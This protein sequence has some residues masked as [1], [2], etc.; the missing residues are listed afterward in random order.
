MTGGR[1]LQEDVEAVRAATDIL[2]VV[3]ERVTLK[4]SGRQWA[5]LC[6]FHNEK[7]PSFTVNPEKGVY[8][9][10]GCGAGGNLFRFVQQTVPCEFPEAVEILARRAGITLRYSGAARSDDGGRRRRLVD[11]HE[12]ALAFYQDTLL[13]SEEARPARGYWKSRHFDGDDARAFHVGYAPDA[14][15]TLVRELGRAGFTADVLIEAG[16]ATRSREGRAID[17]FRNRLMFPIHNQVGEAIGF[18]GRVLPGGQ[19]PKYLNSPETKLY[20]KSR[21]LYNLHRAKGDVLSRHEVVIVEGYTDVIALHKAGVPYAVATCGTALGEGHFDLLRHYGSATEPLRVV[22]AFD[23]DAAR[24]AA[25]ERGFELHGRFNVDVRV[26]RLPAGTDPADLALAHP[27]RA[28]PAVADP[29]PLVEFKLEQVLAGR[30]GIDPESRARTPRAAAA[31]PA[32]HPAQGAR[33]HRAAW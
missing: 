28:P 10:H 2:D 7:S 16:L 24:P 29:A 6:P 20:P 25:G 1:I 14:W 26:A 18:G 17:R 12:A 8:Y 32:G 3:R 11:A 4:R 23:A 33:G 22:P 31:S 13:T 27:A 5:G 19:D 21:T 9:C 15:D 30:P